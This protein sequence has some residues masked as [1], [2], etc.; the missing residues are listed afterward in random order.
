MDI[1]ILVMVIKIDCIAFG[2]LRRS[3]SKEELQM[4]NRLLIG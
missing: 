1:A 3:V 2:I 4:K